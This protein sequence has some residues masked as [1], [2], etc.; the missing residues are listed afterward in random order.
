MASSA[1]NKLLTKN[2]PH[3]FEKIFF[4]L[5]YESFMACLKVSKTW[6]GLLMSK[7]FKKKAKYLFRK[8]IRTDEKK[9]RQASYKGDYAKVRSLILSGM[10]DINCKAKTNKVTPLYE[11]AWGGSDGHNHVIKLLLEGGAKPDKKDKYGMTPLYVVAMRGNMGAVQMLLDAG[12]DPNACNI[13]GETPQSK[14]AKVGNREI[15]KL[16]SDRVAHQSKS[17]TKNSTQ[18]NEAIRGIIVELLSEGGAISA[19]KEETDAFKL[20]VDGWASPAKNRYQ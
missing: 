9:L 6:N 7:S 11:A 10:M 15:A 2:V 12:A 3:I 16:L 4:S 19:R 1:F 8:E 20:L 5:D 14:A 13:Y 18:Q 17:D